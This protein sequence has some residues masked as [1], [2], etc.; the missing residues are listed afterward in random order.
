M[1]HGNLHEAFSY[2]ALLVATLPVLAFLAWVE[3][4][5]KKRPGLYMKV[6]GR[7]TAYIAIGVL[8]LWMLL[9]NIFCI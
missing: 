3:Y 6:Y 2:N 4:S 1:L 9:R 5:R 7:A 8:L